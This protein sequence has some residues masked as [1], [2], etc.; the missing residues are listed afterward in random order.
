MKIC[1]SIRI[2]SEMGHSTHCT[3]YPFIL[4]GKYLDH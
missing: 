3:S 4:R 1:F 2:L